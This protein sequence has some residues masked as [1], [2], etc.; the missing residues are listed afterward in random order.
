MRRRVVVTGLGVVS[1][2]GNTVRAFEQSLRDGRSGVRAMPD[3]EGIEGFDTRVAAPVAEG[4]DEREIPRPYRRSMGPQAIYAALAARRA[5]EDARLETSVVTGGR[6]GLAIGSTLGSAESTHDFFRLY[7]Q[8]RSVVGIK[9]TAF[10]R[11]MGHTC[12]ANVALLLGLT[13]RVIAPLS[14]CASGSQGIGVGYETIQSGAQDVMLCGGADEAHFTAAITFDLVKGTSTRFHDRPEC[15]PRPFDALR[16]GLVV[17]AGGGNRGARGPRARPC[18]GRA[19]PGGAHRVRDELRRG[20]HQPAPGRGYGALHAARDEKRTARSLRY[21]VYQR[22][23]DGD[24][25]RRRRRSGP[26]PA[27]CS[28]TAFPFRASK[29]RPVIRSARVGRSKRSPR[30]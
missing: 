18:A 27:R 14:A 26:R 24:A 30:C 2:I 11:C 16:D 7:F 1:P 17:G 5:L 22:P 10:L 9:G 20:T 19:D 12:A 21:S 13:G 6:C 29:G 23:R 25:A 15:T 4:L 28:A 3:W 8:K